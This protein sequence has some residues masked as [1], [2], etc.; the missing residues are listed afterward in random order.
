MKTQGLA[1]P[2]YLL[3][4]RYDVVVVGSGY[5][6]SIAAS[7]FSRAGYSVCVLERG[8]EY[9]ANDFPNT[10]ASATPEIHIESAEGLIEKLPENPLGLYNFHINKD[11]NVLVGCGLG[12]TSLINANVSLKPDPRVFEDKV[13]PQEIRDDKKGLDEA[14]KNAKEMLKANPYPAGK[15]GYPELQKSKA[16]FK[17]GKALA[18]KTDYLDINVNFDYKGKNHVGVEQLPCNNCGDCCS[19][20]R[21]KAKNTLDK[22]YLPDAKNHGAE[23]F[24]QM[25][26]RHIEKNAD[27]TW[28]VHYLQQPG[29]PLK[30]NPATSFIRADIV[31]LGAGSLG[32]TEILLRSKQNGLA[33]SDKIGSSFSGNGDVLAFSYNS[34]D[35][36]NAIGFGSDKPESRTPVGPCITAIIDARP[37]DKP[38]K[39]GMVIEE[40]SAPGALGAILPKL[41]SSAASAFGEDTDKGFADNTKEVYR[42]VESLTRGYKYGATHNTQTCL[43][44]SNDDQEGKLDL[45]ND[46]VRLSWAGYAK[47]EIFKNVK[48]NMVKAATALGGTYLENPITEE[49]FGE[50]MIT[51]HPLGGCAMGEASDIGVVNHKCEVFDSKSADKKAVHDG[52]Y[53]MDGAVIPRSLG[54]NPLFTICAV[55]ERA[56]AIAIAQRGKKTSYDFPK[57]DIYLEDLSSV[58][59]T[60][61]EVMR[62]FAVKGATSFDDGFNKGKALGKDKNGLQFRLTI[63]MD[64]MEKFIAKKDHLGSITG[65]AECP[66]LSDKPLSVSEGKFNLFIV[67][68]NKS[69]LKNMDYCM[70]LTSQKGEQFYFEGRKN[71]RSDG[72][73]SVEEIWE[74][75]STLYVTIYKG[76]DAKGEV[77]AKGIQKILI[78]DFVDQIKSSNATRINNTEK[79]VKAVARFGEFFFGQLWETYVVNDKS[80]VA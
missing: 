4:D 77:V 40:G 69:P 10:A 36:V 53:V 52:L 20:C 7:R 39:D 57:A 25:D 70:V 5:G 56:A 79:A 65:Y 62:G 27:K 35:K 30:G 16:L 76:K 34:D 51:V 66:L 33:I 13:W 71:V 31:V 12:G 67:D 18:Y 48:A 2:Y 61:T 41:F 44:M 60:F 58:G 78:P 1:S 54:V 64:D 15:N 68:K 14:Y 29:K 63:T 42:Q 49:F 75:T 45:K 8:R 43:I 21:Y 74:D 6:A 73:F 80:K 11:L 26:V 24:T 72:H 32:S 9:L 59:V 38:L 50:K 37:A 46:K 17:S 22:N 23:I 19:G 47:K 55:S 28:T 3:K